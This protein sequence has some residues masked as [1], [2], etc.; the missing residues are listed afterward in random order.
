MVCQFEIEEAQLRAALDVIERSKERGFVATTA[1]FNIARVGEDGT[2]V[3]SE[4]TNRVILKA[5]PTDPNQNWG[6]IK[7]KM[8]GWYRLVDGK[9]E[10]MDS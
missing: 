2:N 4:F 5:H 8:L 6:N 10:D 3:F 9:V 7:D 1:V